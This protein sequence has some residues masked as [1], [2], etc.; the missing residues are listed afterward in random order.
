MGYKECSWLSLLA[1]TVLFLGRAGAFRPVSVVDT[2]SLKDMKITSLSPSSSWFSS[3]YIVNGMK[4]SLM[5]ELTFSKL[6]MKSQDIGSDSRPVSSGLH[7]SDLLLTRNEEGL[8]MK[9][10]STY[11]ERRTSTRLLT[12]LAAVDRDRDMDSDSDSDSGGL[13]IAIE[14]WLGEWNNPTFWKGVVVA[15]CK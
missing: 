13:D 2:N 4:L 10:K 15:I 8:N 12:S 1:L 7:I 3:V 5:R 11:K 9:R 6:F 14:E